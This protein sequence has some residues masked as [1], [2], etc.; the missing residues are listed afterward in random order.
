LCPQVQLSDAAT[1]LRNR[2]TFSEAQLTELA[3]HTYRAGKKDAAEAAAIEMDNRPRLLRGFRFQCIT[4]HRG[5]A[6]EEKMDS[7][8]EKF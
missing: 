2:Q 4:A 8:G 1:V 5:K 7:Q 3:T 6:L